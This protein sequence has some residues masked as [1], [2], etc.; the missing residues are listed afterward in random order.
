MTDLNHVTFT[1]N[2]AADPVYS[3]TS[4]G[5][6]KCTARIGVDSPEKDREGNFQKHTTWYSLT[7]WEKT[8]DILKAMRR[9]N[10]IYVEGSLKERKYEKD[11]VT[12]SSLDITV[13]R[14]YKL[15]MTNTSGPASADFSEVDLLAEEPPY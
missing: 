12:K 10:K 11:G 13:R 14:A 6:A 9:G 4:S 8:A 2:L 15:D 1:G 3:M 5:K 7:A